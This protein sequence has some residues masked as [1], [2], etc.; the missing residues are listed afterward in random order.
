[1]AG[2]ST[3]VVVM[4]KGIVLP[5]E[6]DVT[7]LTSAQNKD[8]GLVSRFGGESCVAGKGRR[9]GEQRLCTSLARQRLMAERTMGFFRQGHCCTWARV[10]GRDGISKSTVLGR[11]SRN[12]MR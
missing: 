6:T 2:D 1:M 11:R 4:E 9:F 7:K 8:I 12:R 3:L 10:L 5:P